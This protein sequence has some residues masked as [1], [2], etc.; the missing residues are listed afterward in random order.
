MLT[1][2]VNIIFLIEGADDHLDEW[3]RWNVR[4]LFDGSKPV[5]TPIASI[6]RELHN[7]WYSRRH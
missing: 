5:N 1:I 4:V 7:P 2:R 6:G 3:L